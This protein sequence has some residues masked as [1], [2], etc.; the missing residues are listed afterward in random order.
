MRT[1]SAITLQA[2]LVIAAISSLPEPAS[3]GRCSC[4]CSGA[5]AMDIANIDV[6]RG[7]SCSMLN[8]RSCY[9]P[10]M[11]SAGARAGS[12]QSASLRH[13]SGYVEPPDPDL[14]QNRH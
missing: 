7:S 1:G 13:C 5:R 4:T 14:F 9:L 11:D 6:P 3:A 12:T 10:A 2:V 8:G